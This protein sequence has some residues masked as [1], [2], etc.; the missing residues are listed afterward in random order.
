MSEIHEHY[1]ERFLKA[2]V[3][4]NKLLSLRK[5]ALTHMLLTEGVMDLEAIKSEFAIK[6]NPQ[7]IC[8]WIGKLQEEFGEH[9]QVKD[10]DLLEGVYKAK[11]MQPSREA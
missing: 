7:Q 4:K 11:V 3:I 9:A 8:E 2:V 6:G 5:A 1:A 10:V